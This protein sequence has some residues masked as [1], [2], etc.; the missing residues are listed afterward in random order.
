MAQCE[1]V[2]PVKSTYNAVN[3]KINNPKASI[4]DKKKFENGNGEY[5]AVN[6]EINNPELENKPVYSYPDYDSIVT[7]DMAMIPFDIPE[8]PLYPISYKTSYVNNR[9]YIAADLDSDSQ[10]PETVMSVPEPYLTTTENE[11]N[12]VFHGISFRATNK[13]EIV[14]DAKIKPAI[15]INIVTDNLA[16]DNLDVQAKQMEEIVS[17]SLADGKSALPYVSTIVFCSS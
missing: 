1:V 3:I 17:A 13:P 2:C 8:I 11:K 9:T 12:P 6:L 5:N 7:A 16:S 15:D 10:K 4:S 14:A